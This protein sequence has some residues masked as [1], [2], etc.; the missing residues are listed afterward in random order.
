MNAGFCKTGLVAET[1]VVSALWFLCN[2]CWSTNHSPHW[3][4]YYQ[5]TLQTELNIMSPERSTTRFM[6]IPLNSNSAF[7]YSVT[8]FSGL[9]CLLPPKIYQWNCHIKNPLLAQRLRTSHH[10][11][12]RNSNSPLVQIFQESCHFKLSLS[13]ILCFLM[14]YC[15]QLLS[16]TMLSLWNLHSCGSFYVHVASFLATTSMSSE[17]KKLVY[18]PGHVLACL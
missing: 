16:I 18:R 14:P 11:F 15:P 5:S 3:S 7:C 10:N 9:V 1:L 12:F 8:F 4:Q 6:T 13:F 17:H 2:L